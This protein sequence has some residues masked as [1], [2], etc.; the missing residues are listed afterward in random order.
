MTGAM[1][2][3][4]VKETAIAWLGALGYAVLHGPDIATRAH[5]FRKEV[6]AA[7]QESEPFWRSRGFQ[8]LGILDYGG[9]PVHKMEQVLE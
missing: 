8:P 2:E 3:S 9:L 7:V 5:G 4:V 6:L 1:I